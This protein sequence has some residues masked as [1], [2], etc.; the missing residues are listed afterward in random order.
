MIIS[1]SASIGSA[2]HAW[3]SSAPNTSRAFTIDEEGLPTRL[4]AFRRSGRTR[5]QADVTGR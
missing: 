3:R 2:F 5:T 4:F 1:G